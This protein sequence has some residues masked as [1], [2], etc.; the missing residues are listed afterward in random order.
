MNAEEK[1]SSTT[2]PSG[3]HMQ[4]LY[5]DL[6]ENGLTSLVSGTV[7]GRI[8]RRGLLGGGGL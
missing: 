8:R 2:L 5:G 1:T 6:N 4:A 7:L 3:P